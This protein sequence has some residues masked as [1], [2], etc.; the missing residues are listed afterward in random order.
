MQKNPESTPLTIDPAM[1]VSSLNHERHESL[2]QVKPP[3]TTTELVDQA[4]FSRTQFDF[5]DG[6][7]TILSIEFRGREELP[8]TNDEGALHVVLSDDVR[9]EHTK[10]DEYGSWAQDVTGAGN[11]QG[12]IL[13]RPTLD[14]HGTQTERIYSA[15]I[16]AHKDKI[17]LHVPGTTEGVIDTAIQLSNRGIGDPKRGPELVKLRESIT[18][19]RIPELD[20]RILKL[21]LSSK[22][23]EAGLMLATLELAGVEGA[24]KEAEAAVED[25]DHQAAVYNLG[26]EAVRESGVEH[27]AHPGEVVSQDKIEKIREAGLVAVHTTPTLPVGGIIKSTSGHTNG[28]MPRDTIHWSMNHAVSSHLGGNFMAR[29]YTVVAPLAGLV[30]SNGAPA[31]MADVDTYF[32]SDSEDSVKLPEGTIVIE[33]ANSKPEE[34]GVIQEGDRWL[35]DTERLKSSAEIEILAS[36]IQEINGPSSVYD[37]DPVAS[38]A[39]KLTTRGDIDLETSIYQAKQAAR[40]GFEIEAEGKEYD[41]PEY[42]ESRARIRE[43]E[44]DATKLEAFFPEGTKLD[45]KSLLA[46]LKDN[47]TL[48][49]NK[50]LQSLLSEGVRKV[51]V[52]EAIKK[53]GGKDFPKG[54]AHYTTGGN[55]FQLK[56]N[57][58]A[59]EL[60][61]STGLHANS[62]DHGLE[63]ATWEQKNKVET[64]VPLPDGSSERIEFDW[65]SIESGSIRYWLAMASPAQRQK[66]MAT[67]LLTFSDKAKQKQDTGSSIDVL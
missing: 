19:A 26:A 4:G 50:Y 10:L 51:L 49:G 23:G 7:G 53:N 42:A 37:T 1:T 29:P 52:A 12:A 44:A 30:E 15:A 34:S 64:R 25:I 14:T 20:D 6:S 65:T 67:G 41:K 24:K 16:E 36:E 59:D 60:G 38:L 62:A 35:L 33:M 48:A 66:A 17:T 31:R 55:D 5:D 56:N 39:R 63:Q 45:E 46:L 58:L 2:E 43:T 27:F 18:T 47:E 21:A 13:E 57:Q 54:G 8:V 22:G 9:P 3:Y 32:V 40:Y 61:V 11:G 28:E